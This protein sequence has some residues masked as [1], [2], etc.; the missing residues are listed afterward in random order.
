MSRARA[1]LCLSLC[2]LLVAPRARLGDRG[3]RLLVQTRV[4]RLLMRDGR[5]LGVA[6]MPVLMNGAPAAGRSVQVHA[7]HVV[8]AGGAINSPA[9]L[10][11]SGAPDPHGRLGVRTFLHPTV[12]STAVFDEPIEGWNGAPQTIYSDHFLGVQPIDGPIGFKLEAPPLYPLLGASTLQGFGAEQAAAL[13]EF[14]RTHALLALM[15]DGFHAESPGGQVALGAEGRGVLDYPLTPF[16]MEGARRALLAMAEIQFAAGA[17]SVTPVHE[18]AR[19]LRSWS[20][21]R[22]AIQSLPMRPYATRVVSAHVMG[23]CGMAGRADLGVVR[24]DGRHWLLE[25]LSVHDGSI[26]PTSLG[27]N[28]QLSIYGLV[29]M[30]ATQLAQDLTGRPAASLA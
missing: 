4:E 22:A 16:V 9:L 15:R 12:L 29:A 6:G 14:P 2:A 3:A 28:P 30:L 13:K 27:V 17:R 18:L 5:V 25:G 24:P 8:V 26:F 7:R 11:R 23:G 21:A 19:P 20:D 1:G 10:M